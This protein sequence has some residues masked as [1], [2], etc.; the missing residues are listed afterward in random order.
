MVSQ[1]GDMGNFSMI[2][3]WELHT[4]STSWWF[5]YRWNQEVN[6]LTMFEWSFV[7]IIFSLLGISMMYINIAQF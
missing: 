5:I 4:V 3:D 2:G 7:T 1:Y 6:H